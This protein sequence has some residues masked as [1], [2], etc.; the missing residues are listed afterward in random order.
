MFL[1]WAL[2]LPVRKFEQTPANDTAVGY[3]VSLS[4]IILQKEFS[5]VL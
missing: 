3:Q 2:A 1:S 4:R 5:I